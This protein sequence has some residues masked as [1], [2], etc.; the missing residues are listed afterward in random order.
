[1]SRNRLY[2]ERSPYLLQHAGNP[3][4]WYP[5][6]DEAF[7]TARREDKPVFLSIGYSTCHWCHVMERESF[8]N[9]AIALIMNENFICVKVDREEH[10]DIDH[11]YMNALHAM[12]ASGGWPLSIFLTPDGKPFFGGTY[13][14]P[15]DS[16]GMHGFDSILKLI[17]KAW[18]SNRTELLQHTDTFLDSLKHTGAGRHE[19]PGEAILHHAAGQFSQHFDPV[20][21]G[22]LEK[23]KFPTAHVLSFL[24]RCWY[25]FQDKDALGMATH[26]L[27]RIAAGGIRDHLAGG[28][29]RYAIDREWLVPHFEKML[30]DQALLATVFTEAFLITGNGEYCRIVR[31]VLGYLTKYLRHPDGGFYCAEDADSEGVEGK[32]YLWS[33]EEIIDALGD[34]DGALFCE[35]HGVTKEGNFE[36][37]N[38]LTA[39]MTPERFAEK[40]GIDAT[41]LPDRLEQCRKI[42]LAVRDKRPRPLRDEK[43]LTDWNGLAI[44][45][46]SYAA[47]ALQEQAFAA[48][49][50]DAALFILSNMRS[51]GRLFRS[52]CK[53]TTAIRGLLTDYAFF[54]NGLIDLYEATFEVQW[55]AEAQSMCG[56]MI[57]LFRDDSGGGFFMVPRDGERLIINSK[58]T[59]DGALPSGNSIAL[60][61]LARLEHA[62]DDP[63]LRELIDVTFRAF[64]PEIEKMPAGYPAMLTALDYWLGPRREAVIATGCSEEENG[65]FISEIYRHFAPRTFVFLHRAGEAGRTL[66][67]VVPF[68]KDLTAPDGKATFY[69]CENRHCRLPA[70]DVDEARRLFVGQ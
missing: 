39:R 4:N 22:F 56:E 8:E 17:A 13:F 53:G 47:R 34:A 26:T 28:F 3:V 18:K 61:A 57:R 37:R 70:T 38:I 6:G 33:R 21:G 27:D 19:L 41:G 51:G 40:R 45:A 59:F 65:L 31:E 63:N 7:E 60:M 42:L 5:W 36:G 54:C 10:P 69:V 32:F 50:S 55:L 64:A 52:W 68:V 43:I 29:H 1:M 49:A 14:P 62:T 9:E 48:A 16:L 24:L 2:F 66:E 35:F 46:F 67:A 23:P 58:E 30:Y 25:R 20:F 44:S 15:N 12:G 11:L